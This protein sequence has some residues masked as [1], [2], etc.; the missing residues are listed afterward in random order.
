MKDYLEEEVDEKYYIHTEKADKLIKDL[1]SETNNNRG[2]QSITFTAMYFA[3]DNPDY[4]TKY[5]R[6][7][8]A[9]TILARDWKG[10]ANF[11]RMNGVMEL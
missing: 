1:L 4:P 3:N 5:E 7:D 9:A 10:P 2:E 8:T 11:V 6:T